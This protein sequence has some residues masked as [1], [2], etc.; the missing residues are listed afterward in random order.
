[1]LL[2]FVGK[3]RGRQREIIAYGEAKR[4]TER[5]IGHA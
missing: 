1:M 5:W 4:Y 2:I 3:Q